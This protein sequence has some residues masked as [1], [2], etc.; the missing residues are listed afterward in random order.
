M[1]R[2]TTQHMDLRFDSLKHLALH[3]I[4]LLG[5]CSLAKCCYIANNT[6]TLVRFVFAANCRAK[7]GRCALPAVVSSSM[8]LS[9]WP[10]LHNVTNELGYQGRFD[11]AAMSSSL[12]ARICRTTAAIH[13]LK[14]T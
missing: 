11:Q 2:S 5:D 12:S 10:L 14:T 8:S 4:S 9:K 7:R 1:H 13:L 3:W 6:L